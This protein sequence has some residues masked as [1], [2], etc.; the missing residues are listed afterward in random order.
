MV[1]KMELVKV[2]VDA[3][4]RLSQRFAVRAAHVDD[5]EGR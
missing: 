1:G 2:D 3:A 4:P 5:H